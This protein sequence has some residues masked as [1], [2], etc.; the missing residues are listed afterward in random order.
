MHAEKNLVVLDSRMQCRISRLKYL[1][2]TFGLTYT[3]EMGRCCSYV[4]IE[5][6]NCW[7]L[8][9]RSF[10]IS[11]ALGARAR[12]SGK[13]TSASHWPS[14][15]DVIIRAAVAENP[16]LASSGSLPTYIDRRQEPAWHDPAV[17]LRLCA[18]LGLSN[19]ATVS[20]ALSLGA[21]AMRDL[22]PV[23]NYFAHKNEDTAERVR[24]IGRTHGIS[25]YA[26]SLSRKKS[27]VL[28]VTSA[29]PG[30]PQSI[31]NDWLDELA[32]TASLMVD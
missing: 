10:I 7:V 29:A 16:R 15:N 28:V 1:T 30:R 8:F 4:V 23:R 5:A 22:P 32:V 25:A 2:S 11:A 26:G 13:I 27:P 18:A 9:S 6:L 21:T 14:Q 12:N 3:P 17:I 20:Q 24:R 31:L 19:G